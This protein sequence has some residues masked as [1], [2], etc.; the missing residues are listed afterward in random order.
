MRVPLGLLTGLSGVVNRLFLSL[1]LLLDIELASLDRG[2]LAGRLNLEFEAWVGTGGNGEFRF[3]RDGGRGRLKF[4]TT[5][6]AS[7]EAS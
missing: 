7:V 5:G 2:G 4:G 3:V 1:A 6:G